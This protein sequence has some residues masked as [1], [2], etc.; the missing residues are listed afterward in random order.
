MWVTEAVKMLTSTNQL[1]GFH[2]VLFLINWSFYHKCHTGICYSYERETGEY[3]FERPWWGTRVPA[4]SGLSRLLSQTSSAPQRH[5]A[6]MTDGWTRARKLKTIIGEMVWKNRHNWE[7][8]PSLLPLTV[9]WGN[10]SLFSAPAS[11]CLRYGSHPAEHYQTSAADPARSLTPKKAKKMNRSRD[12]L[13]S[14]T[15]VQWEDSEM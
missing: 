4:W 10:V 7:R 15:R 8:K 12:K 9:C 2:P 11:F 6:V 1:T 5:V 3:S 13:A 14:L